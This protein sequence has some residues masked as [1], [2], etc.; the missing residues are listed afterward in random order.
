MQTTVFLAQL[1][2]PV[3]LALGIGFFASRRYYIR[4]YRDLEKETLAVL[5][6]AM[7][8]IPAAIVQIGVHNSWSSLPEVVVSLLGWLLLLKGLVLAIAPG[9]A[10]K[11]GN[12]EVKA[13][14]IPGIGAV[15][16]IIGA[17]LSWFGFLS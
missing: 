10:D 9:W 16:V 5:T 7:L 1:W 4:L 17:Y 13:R 6:I 15:L 11:A 12:W 8:A 3:M 14:L 2:G